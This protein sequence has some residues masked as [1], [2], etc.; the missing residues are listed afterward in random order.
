MKEKKERDAAMKEK[1]ERDTAMKEKEKRDV[2]KYAADDLPTKLLKTIM[3]DLISDTGNN[4]DDTRTIDDTLVDVDPFPNSK[5]IDSVVVEIDRGLDATTDEI[6]DFPPSMAE[7]VLDDDDLYDD[8]E[9]VATTSVFVPDVIS[10][11]PDPPLNSTNSN[12]N[13]NNNN[14]TNRNKQKN[15]ARTATVIETDVEFKP[16]IITPDDETIQEDN[17]SSTTTTYT[18][19]EVEL[20]LED[21]YDDDGGRIDNSKS[22]DDVA[23]A[24]VVGDYEEEEEEEKENIIATVTLRAVDVVLFVGEKTLTSG[25]P[26]LVDGCNNIATRTD[27]INREGMG[28]EGW[29]MLKHLNKGNKRY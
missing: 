22:L 17:S 5:I 3:G 15:N 24:T 10:S 29:D 13:S 11:S 6:T 8:D 25:I 21:K 20:V 7:V 1:E 23:Y 4:E 12:S 26:T 9:N 16:T 28:K 27:E 18:T 19:P 2:D 14:N